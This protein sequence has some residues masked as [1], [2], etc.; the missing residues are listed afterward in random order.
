MNDK[1][2]YDLYKDCTQEELNNCLMT[3]CNYGEFDKVRYLLIS[4]HL[5]I[6]ADIDFVGGW[7]LSYACLNNH[8]DIV[9]YLLTSPELNHHADIH[10]NNDH[11]LYCAIES[12]NIEIVKYLISSPDL[13]EHA[14]IHAK[15]DGIFSSLCSE[16]EIELLTYLIFEY[17]IEKTQYIEGVLNENPNE[18]KEQVKDMF[19]RRELNIILEKDLSS[20]RIN[21]K[22]TKL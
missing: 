14:N 2:L 13:K 5:T 8:I 15:E 3:A 18:F 10:I 19:F 20:D 1:S 22:K 21:K 6:H 7:P 16:H 12:G 17:G 11:P 9:K 4:S